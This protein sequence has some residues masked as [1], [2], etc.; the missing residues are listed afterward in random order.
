MRRPATSLNGSVGD[1][2]VAGCFAYAT[3]VIED[4]LKSLY[5]LA[6]VS[7]MTPTEFV[8]IVVFTLLTGCLLGAAFGIARE[9]L[10]GEHN[11]DRSFRLRPRQ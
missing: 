5:A 2:S 8:A 4:A 10:A 6:E 1:Q 7:G 11:A 9:N 3:S